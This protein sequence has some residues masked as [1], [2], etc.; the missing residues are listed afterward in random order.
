M[1]ADGEKGQSQK[2]LGSDGYSVMSA[3]DQRFLPVFI[4]VHLPSAVQRFF[5]CMVMV[6][7][8]GLKGGEALHSETPDVV[9]YEIKWAAAPVTGE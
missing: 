9:S 3:L 6:E 1:N 7:V 8:S 4:C 5:N 2:Y